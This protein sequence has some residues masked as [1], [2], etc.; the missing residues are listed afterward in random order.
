M[1]AVAN[2]TTM[3]NTWSVNRVLS[4]RAA[5]EFKKAAVLMGLIYS[6]DLPEGQ[7]T[8]VKGFRRTGYVDATATLAEATALAIGTPRED[9][10]VDAT[11][12]KAVRVDG[13]SI[14]NQKFS[15]AG[16]NS[17]VQSQAR[18]LARAVDNQGLAL[19]PS[20]TNQVDAEGALTIDDLDEAQLLILAG[21][22]PDANKNLTFVGSL[23]GMRNL[24]S[25]IRDSGG[26][27]MSNER[28]LSI[29]NG[30]PQ[31]NGYYGSLPGYDLYYVPSGLTAVSTQSSQCLFHGDW[32]FAGMY[33][34]QINV[35]TTEKGSEGLY[36]EVVSY[37]FW[38]QILWNA[39]AACEVLSA[40]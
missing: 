30:P 7:A 29:F 37:F 17:Y 33:D 6:E 23:R 12:A 24:K 31:L 25:D 22:I 19:F 20:V 28:F 27:A 26:A 16:L 38:A 10:L 11:A 4:Q 2:V 3:S 14:E 15:I 40:S 13:V 5:P 21:E 32:A 35:V 8:A 18:S 34:R 9:T 39:A 1:G 36:T